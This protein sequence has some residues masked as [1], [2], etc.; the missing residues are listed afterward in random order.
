[1][2]ETELESISKLTCYGMMMGQTYALKLL[3]LMID[4]PKGTTQFEELFHLDPCSLYPA[5]VD[6]VI[7]YIFHA[8]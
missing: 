6:M 3:K 1:M 2:T 4:F 5:Y 8:L 7:E